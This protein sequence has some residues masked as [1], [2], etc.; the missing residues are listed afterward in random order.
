MSQPGAATLNLGEQRLHL[1]ESSGGNTVEVPA[2]TFLAHYANLL[3]SQRDTDDLV[4]HIETGLKATPEDQK[5]Q[6]LSRNG[7]TATNFIGPNEDTVFKGLAGVAE[8]IY[9]HCQTWNETKQHPKLQQRTTRLICQPNHTTASEVRGGSMK[10]DARF[11]LNEIGDD[12]HV[13]TSAAV[14]PAEFKTRMNPKNQID[15]E[16]KVLGAVG[17]ILYNDPCRRFVI[18]FTIEDRMMRFW[19]FSRSHIAVTA[20]FDYHANPRLFIRFV[21]YMT[22]ASLEDLGYDP[23]VQRIHVSEED[24][25]YRF[26]VGD[27]V[28]QTIRI[29]HELNLDI[30]T[31]ATRVWEVIELDS[32]DMPIGE[33]Q[34]LKDVWLYF[35]ATPESD[36]YNEIFAALR[37]LDADGS[38]SES[39]RP[40]PLQ[41][42]SSLEEDAKRYF[43]NIISDSVVTVNGRADEAR[44]PPTGYTEFFYTELDEEQVAMDAVIV[45]AQRGDVD[46]CTPKP[47]TNKAYVYPHKARIHRQV[48]FLEVCETLYKVFSYS[49]FALGLAQ[50]VHGLAYLRL[51]GFVHRDISPGNCLIYEGQMKISDLEYARKYISQGKNITPLTGTPGFMAVEYQ[52]GQYMFQVGGGR[53]ANLDLYSRK[54]PSTIRFQFNFL[55]DLEIPYENRGRR[56]TRQYPSPSPQTL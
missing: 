37:Q 38:V 7:W 45:A 2:E 4:S 33:S 28:Y 14:A 22:F 53:K 30:V 12:V 10:T 52:R 15:N 20:Q 17:H 32:E 51:A 27:K 6:T 13:P 41:Q 35:D 16:S 55:H 39:E 31:R 19:Y 29:I 43:M 26:T 21:I 47:K 9:T 46:G 18:A 49:K 42:G 23:T 1:K 40:P 24:I 5:P 8:E 48:I 36:I 3:H 50:L 25:Q 56:P 11:I 54:T 34:V 44:E